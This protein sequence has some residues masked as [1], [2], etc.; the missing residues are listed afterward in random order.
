M[1]KHLRAGYTLTQDDMRELR[2]LFRHRNAYLQG[3]YYRESRMLTQLEA[4]KKKLAITKPT[5]G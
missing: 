2:S 4:A 3:M 1:P 5:P